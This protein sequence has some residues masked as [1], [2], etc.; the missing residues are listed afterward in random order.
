MAFASDWDEIRIA[1]QVNI[2]FGVALIGT[3]LAF[4]PLFDYTRL[5]SHFYGWAIAVLT[6]AMVFCY[7]RQERARVGASGAITSEPA[8]IT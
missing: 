5:P 3:I 6:L 1:A 4:L 8:P 2:L 7:W